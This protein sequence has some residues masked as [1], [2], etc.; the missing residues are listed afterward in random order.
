MIGSHFLLWKMPPQ[1]NIFEL[2][3]LSI[4]SCGSLEKEC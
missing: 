2:A 1:K 3:Y 4:S